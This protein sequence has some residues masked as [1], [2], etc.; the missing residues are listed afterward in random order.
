VADRFGSYVPVYIIFT[1]ICVLSYAMVQ[2]IYL[3]R[4]K[5]AVAA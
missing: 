5:S 4:K 1:V 3:K 2:Y